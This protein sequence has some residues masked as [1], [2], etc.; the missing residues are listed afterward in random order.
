MLNTYICK[1]TSFPQSG[2]SLVATSHNQ[3]V[4]GESHSQYAHAFLTVTITLK[5]EKGELA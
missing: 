1:L 5:V 4:D 3:Y 2:L